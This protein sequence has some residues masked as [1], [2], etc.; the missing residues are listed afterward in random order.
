MRW[1]QFQPHDGLVRAES[2]QLIVTSTYLRS[3]GCC[4]NISRLSNGD[5]KPKNGGSSSPHFYIPDLQAD[6]M[7]FGL[8]P[9]S[10]TSGFKEP[11]KIG[12][13]DELRA[14][15]E[16]F[17]FSGDAS[18][19]MDSLQSTGF[20]Y[21]F[22]DLIPLVAPFM[23][24][25]ASQVVKVPSPLDRPSWIFISSTGRT[26][27]AYLLREQIGQL[28]QRGIRASSKLE[29]LLESYDDLD[30]TF[31]RWCQ[32]TEKD[33]GEAMSNEQPIKF[34]E[35]VHDFWDDIEN[36]FQGQEAASNVE[37]GSG[38]PSDRSHIYNNLVKV[39]LRHAVLAES[40]ADRI[41]SHNERRKLFPLGNRIKNV[42]MAETLAQYFYRLEPM[43]KEMNNLGHSF[44]EASFLEIWAHL[45]VR[46]FCW[47]HCH[48][49]VAG[50]TVPSE[51]WNSRLPIY[52][53]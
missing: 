38:E 3:M 42:R 34:L 39:H 48:T 29:S 53:G 18:K 24:R 23:R 50:M 30:R 15:V 12:T 49:M 33:Y 31:P 41:L 4:V 6:A 44:G 26:A 13:I 40:Y 35:E 46:G 14:T 1:S 52:I 7:G 8:L 51:Y 27:F 43:R 5:G 45:M 25:R 9:V 22:L 47:H 16:Q 37:N 19:R 10:A 32:T 21:S 11:F 36:Y 2:N 17:E 28:N 20:L